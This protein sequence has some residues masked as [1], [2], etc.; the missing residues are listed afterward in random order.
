[1]KLI[2]PNEVEVITIGLKCPKC[3]NTWGIRM[4]RFRGDIPL[5]RFVCENCLEKEQERTENEKFCEFT[6]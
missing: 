6:T 5:S 3:G 2:I 1:M 4:D